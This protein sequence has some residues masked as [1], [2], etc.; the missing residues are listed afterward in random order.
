MVVLELANGKCP[1]LRT[2]PCAFCHPTCLA[3]QAVLCCP[4]RIPTMEVKQVWALSEFSLGRYPYEAKNFL[5]LYEACQSW[6]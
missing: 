2:W 1:C 3:P 5:D 4:T 6:I